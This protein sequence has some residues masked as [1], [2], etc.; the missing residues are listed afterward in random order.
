MIKT[1]TDRV[2]ELETRIKALHPYDVPEFL[3]ISVLDGSRDYLSW[4]AENTQDP[5]SP[6]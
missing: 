1:T 4:V 3:V 5:S 6:G 2:H